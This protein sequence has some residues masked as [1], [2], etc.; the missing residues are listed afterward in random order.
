MPLIPAALLAI[1][2]GARSP[3]RSTDRFLWGRLRR[4]GM[5][6]IAMMVVSIGLSLAAARTSSCSS[7]AASPG[8]Y[9]DY[10]VQHGIE[11]GPITTSRRRTCGS[12]CIVLVVIVGVASIL[13]RTRI[14]KAMRAVSDN[15]DLAASS[16]IDVDAGHPLR[17]GRSAAAWPPSAAS[18]SP[19][20]SR[21]SSRWAS[22]SCC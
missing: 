8:P 10:H 5:G 16:G 6:L 21:C 1:L 13:Q 2:I 19:S 17:V 18:C 3:A 11:I 15:P 4:R 12:S 22:S 14:G 20:S 9:A 7:S